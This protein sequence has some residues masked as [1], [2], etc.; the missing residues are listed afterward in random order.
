MIKKIISKVT[1]KQIHKSSLHNLTV[2]IIL[3]SVMAILSLTYYRY[4]QN[5]TEKLQN[6]CN[7]II[8]GEQYN[9]IYELAKNQD[10]AVPFFTKSTNKLIIYNHTGPL[11]KVSCDIKF[12]DKRVYSVKLISR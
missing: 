3:L 8:F 12:S 6:F 10:L 11:F 5:H 7:N 9:K 2:F 4:I 1:N